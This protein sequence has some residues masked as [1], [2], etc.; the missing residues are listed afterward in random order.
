VRKSAVDSELAGQ[1]HVRSQP[2]ES[3]RVGHQ[4]S[5]HQQSA[6]RSGQLPVSASLALQRAAFWKTDPNQ[7]NLT[8][9]IQFLQ[10]QIQFIS[11]RI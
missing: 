4:G 11:I 2:P 1:S 8:I 5:G 10:R 9:Q 3:E 6:Q 7:H